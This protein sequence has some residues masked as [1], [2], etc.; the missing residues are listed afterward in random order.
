MSERILLAID[1]A[2]T[3][4][5]V[6]TGSP[7]GA[8]RSAADWPAGYRHGETLLPAVERLLVEGGLSRDAIAAV[9]VGTGPGTFTGL[10]VGIATAKGIAHG[11]GC[12]I[13]GVATGAAL[14]AA[15]AG[16][17]GVDPSGIRL[18]LPA[19]PTDRILV[20]DG[21]APTLLPA[22]E[23]PS[24][25]PDDA[26]PADEAT[27]DDPIDVAV[28]LDGRAPADACERGERARAGLAAAL[29]RLGAARLARGDADDL[30]R[31]VPEYVTLPRGAAPAS[32]EVSWSH[33]HR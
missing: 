16:D 6:A 2:T 3:R 9:I 31:L 27:A 23:A 5:V 4:I 15:A 21:A 33:D 7:D 28:D 30:A 22:G 29:V 18:L 32:G 24:V 13:V 19:G 25:E 1:T 17:L 26:T 11:L 10:R 14:M 8:V 12:P 20:R